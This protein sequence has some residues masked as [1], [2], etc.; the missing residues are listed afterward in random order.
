MKTLIIGGTGFIGSHL[1]EY[2]VNKKISVTVMDRYNSIYT[3]GNMMFADKNI[4]KKIK[5]LFGDIRDIDFLIKKIKNFD[6]VINL[7]ALIGIPYSYISPLAYVKTNIEGTINILEACKINRIKKIIITSTSEVYGSAIYTPIDESHKLQPQSPYSASKIAADF[8]AMSYFYS[9]NLPVTILRPFNT[10]GP[11]Q[12]LRAIIPSLL[13]QV[14]NT[15]GKKVLVGDLST[16][17]DFNYVED[18]CDGFYKAIKTKKNISGEIINLGSGLSISIK[19]LINIFE[20][21]FSYKI[22]TTQ[23]TKRLRPK[24]SEVKILKASNIKAKKI[25]NWISKSS[26][27]KHLI[28]YLKITIDWYKKNKDKMPRV[29][30]V[31]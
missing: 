14:L 19:Q 7:A 31:D 1:A 24:K 15:N 18:I 8:L 4:L 25:L 21:I 20:N 2:L 10:F 12:S 11:R 26:T 17:R 9:Y 28:Q 16:F 3:E 27:K 6:V 5:F 13:T 29:S 22:N 23:D 30:Y